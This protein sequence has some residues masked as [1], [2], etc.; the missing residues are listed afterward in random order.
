[1]VAFA[2]KRLQVF[3]S[4]TYTD[5]IPERQAAVEAVL[6]AGHIP[7]GME[8]FAAGDQSQMEVI[9]QWI[10]E[11]DVYMLILGG[12]YGSID[13][14]SG[15]S[16]TQ[17]EYDY[18]VTQGKP[19]F[20][21][22]INETALEKKIR[23]AGT[24]I[25]ETTE[26][27]L[28]NTFRNE[29]LN[30]MIKYWDDVKDIKLAVGDALREIERRDHLVGWIKADTQADVVSLTNEIVRLSKENAELRN[31][32]ANLKTKTTTAAG[33]RI[34]GLEPSDMKILL[35]RKNCLQIFHD[36]R[37]TFKR[38]P[39]IRPENA[40]T[41]DAYKE[42]RSIGLL[43]ISPTNSYALTPEGR[44]FMNYLELYPE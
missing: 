17:L 12:R 4:S 19:L 39:S 21:C 43:D 37:D 30:R 1:M 2:R 10:D 23:I 36:L 14:V 42:L 35:T 3:I 20:A 9:Q 6:N 15:K 16:Y 8:L 11:S 44:A 5:L 27:K 26:P 34:Y 7:A 40:A 41:E 38:I 32:V 33:E 24:K 13:P 18:A 29:V 31:E 25:I 22:V 28:L